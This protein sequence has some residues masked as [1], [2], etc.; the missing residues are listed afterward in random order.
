M[1]NCLDGL[2]QKPLPGLAPV[3]MQQ[4]AHAA[5]NL[6]RQIGG[7]EPEPFRY[8]DP[9]IMATIGR[10]RGVAVLGDRH[11]T[12]WQGWLTWLYH[13][14]LRIVDLENRVMVVMRWAWAYTAWRWGARLIVENEEPEASPVPVNKRRPFSPSA[15]L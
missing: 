9:G 7:L 5:H 8:C 1:A 6:L 10:S 12:G 11:L 2:T 14:L 15:E 4:G 3:A 13:H